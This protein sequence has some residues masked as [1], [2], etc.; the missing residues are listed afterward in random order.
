MNAIQIHNILKAIFVLPVFLIVPYLVGS[1]ITFGLIR[2]L[3]LKLEKISFFNKFIL[4]WS[5]GFTFLVVLGYLMN[6][7]KI[8]NLT[9][10]SILILLFSILGT[11]IKSKEDI[12]NRKF[13]ISLK[14]SPIFLSVFIGLVA[15]ILILG[16]TKVGILSGCDSNTH[17][18]IINLI[19]LDN[20][21]YFNGDYLNSIHLLT[22]FG[23]FFSNLIGYEN[24]LLF[25][26]EILL[27]ATYSFGIYN[28]SYL[29]TKNKGISLI[30]SLIGIFT[31]TYNFVPISLYEISPRTIIL[32][33]FPIILSYFYNVCENENLKNLNKSDFS[34]FLILLFTFTL[35]FF[36]L[37]YLTYSS[38]RVFSFVDSIGIILPLFLIISLPLMRFLFK[39]NIRRYLFLSLPI[40]YLG[41]LVHTLMGSLIAIFIFSYLIYERF[42]SNNEKLKK[43]IIIILSISTLFLFLI[44]LFWNPKLLFLWSENWDL[45]VDG[46]INIINSFMNMYNLSIIIFFFI[47]LF[48]LMKNKNN[49]KYG[50]IFFITLIGIFLLFLP[51]PMMNR[52]IGYL[53]PL[54]AIISAFG[55]FNVLN[56]FFRKRIFIKVIFI[57]L[58]SF[59][60]FSNSYIQLNNSNE[61]RNI[62]SCSPEYFNLASDSLDREDTFDNQII[63]LSLDWDYRGIAQRSR[64]YHV[65]ARNSTEDPFET[66]DCI[67]EI[68]LLNDSYTAY[69]K[70]K[71]LSNNESGSCTFYFCGINPHQYLYRDGR[72]DAMEEKVINS[73]KIIITTKYDIKSYVGVMDKFEDKEYFKKI[74]EDS[75]NEIYIF[76]VNPEPGVP[77]EI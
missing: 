6:Y 5:I 36:L 11:I 75:E 58:I 48:S 45:K 72:C 71:N 61:E 13:N 59:L 15:F 53:N 14:I 26:L 74:Y 16:F 33:L 17:R 77:F 27:F 49:Q 19:T 20:F 44:S 32:V 22:S 18:H 50:S 23:I 34:K 70:I 8:F 65:F 60:I 66:P 62:F 3:S 46:L 37:L 68:F 55:L 10:Y 30:S 1:S 9:F 67:K 51:F 39:K 24:I 21:F 29:F 42:I 52:L 64:S 57:V 28:L 56:L 40:I 43:V 69:E 63:S 76:G 12:L 35:F 4:Y 38:Q 31:L 2:L 25:C 47:G 54:V 7:F 41:I 73:K